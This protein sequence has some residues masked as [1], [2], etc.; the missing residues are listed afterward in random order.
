MDPAASL[1]DRADGIIEQGQAFVASQANLGKTLTFW[2]VG[3]EIHRDV[4]KEQRADYGQQI[5]VT[6]SRQL[7]A[8]RGRSYEARNLRRMIQ[9]AQQFPDFEIV[10][11]LSTQLSWSHFVELLPLTH[12]AARLFYAE[13]AA[14]NRLGVHALRGVIERKAFERREIANAQIALG[15][16]V[17]LDTFH[18]PYL[19]DFLGLEDGYHERDLESAI[20]HDIQ[21][22]LLDVGRG[23]AFVARQ[24]R[25]R[26]LG[27]GLQLVCA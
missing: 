10:S 21:A 25:S 27:G 5:V 22:F 8:K 23:W 24:K 1:F 16:A 3:R 9:F 11:T 6:L 12:P 17:P 4:L 26:A 2:R 20:A 19:L 15:S 13:Q 18:D 7:A 14:V